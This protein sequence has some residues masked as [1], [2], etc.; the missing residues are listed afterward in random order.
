MDFSFSEETL[1]MQETLRKFITEEMVP[2]QE[3]HKI[4]PDTPP[5][6]DLRKQL[7]KRSAELGFYGVDMPESA[8]GMEIFAFAR[9]AK[10]S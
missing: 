1:M 5:P 2:L 9:F 8:G 7:R 4:D 6:A 3:K 10:T